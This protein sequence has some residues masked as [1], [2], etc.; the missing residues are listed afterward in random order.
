[1]ATD[2]GKIG[3]LT[4]VA[5]LADAREES[6]AAVGLPTFRHLTRSRR[7]G[8]RSLA[9]TSARTSSP[10]R[11]LP[12]HDWARGN[13]A[14]FV[15]SGCGCARSSI[16]GRRTGWGPVLEEVRA[17]RRSVGVCDMS[18]PWQDRCQGPD[19]AA[20]LD[21]ALR[22]HVF[23]ARGRPRSLRHD[24]AR[25]RVRARRRHGCAP[26]REPLPDHDHDRARGRASTST[27]ISV[28]RCCGPN[29][30]CS[31]SPS[32]ISGRNSRWPGRGRVI[33]SSVCSTRCDISNTAFP[34]MANGEITPRQRSARPPLPDLI[35]GRTGL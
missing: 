34:Y 9:P 30:M 28:T 7:H 16:R 10:K 18:S 25:R 15:G 32:R 3:E 20:F 29:S 26:R 35:F 22:Q 6:I 13:G 33:C 1:M 14:V 31:S 24:A 4:G 8:A 5:A 17:V 23:Q 19:A 21:R 11:L 2:Q 12:L 27:C